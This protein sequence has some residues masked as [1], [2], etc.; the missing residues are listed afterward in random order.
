MDL[1][2]KAQWYFIRVRR[3]CK[4]KSAIKALLHSGIEFPS[5]AMALQVIPKS[6]LV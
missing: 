4:S 2:N 5:L 1:A 6:N 3:L